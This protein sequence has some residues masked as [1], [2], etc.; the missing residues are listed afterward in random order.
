MSNRAA[1]A[2]FEGDAHDETARSEDSLS[3]IANRLRTFRDEREWERFHTPRNLAMSI[4][5]EC[6]ELLEHFQWVSDDDIAAHVA[7]RQQE[8]ADELAD[9]AIYVI[10]LADALGISLPDAIA[11]KIESNERRYPADAARGTATK[12]TELRSRR[13]P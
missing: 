10:Q 2:R 6:G 8:V 4:A 5:I 7:E 3:A 13:L 11:K 1:A 12:Y 9:V